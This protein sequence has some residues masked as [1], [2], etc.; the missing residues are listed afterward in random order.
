[1]SVELLGWDGFP[2]VFSCERGSVWVTRLGYEIELSRLPEWELDR[3]PG[4]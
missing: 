4:A 1:M 3:P 2:A